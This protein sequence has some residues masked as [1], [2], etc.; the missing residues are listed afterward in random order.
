MS[1]KYEVFTTLA[2]NSATRRYRASYKTF[3]G[4]RIRAAK[5]TGYGVIGIVVNRETGAVVYRGA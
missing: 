1:P 2:G 4:A 5:I 3:S